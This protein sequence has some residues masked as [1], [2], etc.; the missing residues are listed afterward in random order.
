MNSAYFVRFTE[1]T[2]GPAALVAER[3][4]DHVPCPSED[5]QLRELVHD[6]NP[7]AAALEHVMPTQ[8]VIETG[9]ILTE[10][11]A[12][13]DDPAEILGGQRRHDLASGIPSQLTEAR[14]RR[15]V[16]RGVPAIPDVGTEPAP[17][18]VV[19]DTRIL[20]DP[21]GERD[22]ERAAVLVLIVHDFLQDTDQ[23]TLQPS[24][25]I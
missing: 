1:R 9:A 15:I 19:L 3:L 8:E 18:V 10:V 22:D 5:D 6:R 23:T 17:H 7:A 12:G 14:G 16:R 24:N 13:R 11:D 2:Q 20:D 25:M 4:L 21:L